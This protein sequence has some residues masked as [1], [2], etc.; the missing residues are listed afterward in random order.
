[1]GYINLGIQEGAKLVTGGSHM[2]SG[3]THG[4]YLPPTIFADVD[5]RMRIAQEEIFGPVLCMIPFQNVDEAVQLANDS[6][7]GLSSA[8]FAKNDNVAVDIARRIRAGQCFVQGAHF[9]TDAP[10]GGYKRSGN[11]REWGDEGL[12][13][14]VEVKAVLTR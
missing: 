10:F 3:L 5:N 12:L 7:Y 8:V 9:T 6:I 13:E 14:F 1:M 11:G 4:A 2:P